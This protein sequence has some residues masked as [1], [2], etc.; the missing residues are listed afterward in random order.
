MGQHLFR[1][2]DSLVIVIFGACN[3]YGVFR[4]AQTVVDTI[5]FKTGG[6]AATKAEAA[7]GF[8]IYPFEYPGQFSF[9]RG[10]QASVI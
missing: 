4:R 1:H 8:F 3:N 2:E 6:A 7:D 10:F 5:Q 9:F